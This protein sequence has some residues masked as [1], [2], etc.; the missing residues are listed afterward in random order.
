MRSA[1]GVMRDCPTRYTV[2]TVYRSDF[3]VPGGGCAGFAVGPLRAAPRAG[4]A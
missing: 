3:A 4:A 1:L 2:G